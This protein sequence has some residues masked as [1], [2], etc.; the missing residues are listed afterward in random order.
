MGVKKTNDFKITANCNGC[1]YIDRKVIVTKKRWFNKPLITE[2]WETVIKF[3]NGFPLPKPFKS[4]EDAES[5]ARSIVEKETKAKNY[6][7]LILKL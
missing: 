1:Y 6:K 5:Y 2:I 7:P 4:Q 3:N